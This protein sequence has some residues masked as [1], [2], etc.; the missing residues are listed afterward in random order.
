MEQVKGARHAVVNDVVDGLWAQVKRGHGRADNAAHFSHAHHVA[1]VRQVQRGLAHQQDEA[2]RSLSTTS[3]A[4]VS[5]LSL[6]PW[7]TDARVRMEH[8]AITMPA[9]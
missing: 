4:R 7:A 2:A 8:G 5:K 6:K 9:H 3:A 1:Q